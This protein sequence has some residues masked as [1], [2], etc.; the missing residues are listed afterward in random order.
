[1]FL[2]SDFTC[3]FVHWRP[4]VSGQT[5][6][7][8]C[9]SGSFA[10]GV[11]GAGTASGAHWQQ[12]THNSSSLSATTGR[13]A[14]AASINAFIYQLFFCSVPTRQQVESRIEPPWVFITDWTVTV[15][16]KLNDYFST[17]GWP[18]CG[19]ILS[20][21][22]I[23]FDQIVLDW[24]DILSHCIIQSAHRCRH[25]R[26]QRPNKVLGLLVQ[27]RDIW[28]KTSTSVWWLKLFHI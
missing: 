6:T 21:V 12:E 20:L 24:N 11:G 7:L 25:P 19:P 16:I 2:S 17:A 10:V 14:C 8:G 13:T 9:I 5:F 27:P 18:A 15:A 4:S 1:M 23:F 3:A 26:R 22:S 28:A